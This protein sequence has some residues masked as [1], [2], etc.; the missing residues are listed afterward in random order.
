VAYSFDAGPNAM[1]FVLKEHLS[2]L[3]S[4]IIRYFPAT[5]L[6]IEKQLTECSV[7]EHIQ[8]SLDKTFLPSTPSSQL[9]LILHTSGG[10]GPV[11]ISD[12][13]LE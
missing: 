5:E 6:R 7:P 10:T 12:Q 11:L 2:Q 1:I 13:Q 4:L 9:Q 8:S 3:S